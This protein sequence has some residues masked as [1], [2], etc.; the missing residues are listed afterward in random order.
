MQVGRHGDGDVDGVVAVL[1]D[2]QFQVIGDIVSTLRHDR[3]G[4]L[5]N[6]C[7]RPSSFQQAANRDA[8][9]LV[10][11]SHSTSLSRAE[12]W[13]SVDS[14]VPVDFHLPVLVQNLGL[15]ES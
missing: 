5:M 6:R 15:P 12:Q 13:E 4:S 2:S 3:L 8:T 11:S 1:D 7:V 14:T 10:L 9:W